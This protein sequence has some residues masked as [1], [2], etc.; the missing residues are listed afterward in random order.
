MTIYGQNSLPEQFKSTAAIDVFLQGCND[1]KA[2]IVTLDNG[3]KTMEEGI[4]YMKCALSYQNLDIEAKN[5][6]KSV[7][8]DH[9][10]ETVESKN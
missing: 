8:V 6:V 1:R 10:G 9:V 4:D 7:T 5:E 3:S 2:A